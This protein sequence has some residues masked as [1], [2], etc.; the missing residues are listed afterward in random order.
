MRDRGIEARLAPSARNSRSTSFA[1]THSTITHSV[2]TDKISNT[3]TETIKIHLLHIEIKDACCLSY[4]YTACH[5]FLPT[6][7]VTDSRMN[8]IC[9][10]AFSCPRD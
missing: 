4:F 6:I 2:K 1:I 5:I 8:G 3:A 10:G 7:T 9:Y